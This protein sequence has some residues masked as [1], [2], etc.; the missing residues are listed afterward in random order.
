M[1]YLILTV[2]I[3]L[4]SLLNATAQ[5]KTETVTIKTEIACDH[6]KVCESCGSN[7]ETAIYKLKGVKRVDIL[8]KENIIRVAYNT[9][10]VTLEDIKIAITKSGFSADELKADATAYANLDDCCKKSE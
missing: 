1:K 2:A 7:L 4:L 10:K 6:C 9:K 5:Q 8:E 3:A